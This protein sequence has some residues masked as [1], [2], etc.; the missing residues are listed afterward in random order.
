MYIT[1]HQPEHMPWLG[2]FHKLDQVETCVLLDS[3]P[4]SK[5]Y[6]QNRNK[7]RNQQGWTWITV[8]VHRTLGTL[9]KDVEI[10]GDDRWKKKWMQTIY[11]S[12]NKSAYAGD[13]LG[14]IEEIL[15]RE[16]SNIS[17][18]NINLIYLLCSYLGIST[19]FI[20]SSE[21]E[22]EGKGSDLILNICQVMKASEYLS[23]IS[24]RDY[25]KIDE[26]G[27]S[28]IS[29]FFQEF[30]HPIYQQLHE[31]FMPC[32]SV[33]DLLCNHGTQSLELLRGHGV[34]TIDHLYT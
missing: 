32:M 33:I 14:G 34:P 26:F 15:N 13:Y 12:Y 27:N 16:W 11:H 19:R 31:P 30:Y 29:V 18:L 9:I 23:G 1:I 2:F 8:P 6:F 5:N 17:D 7:V 3:V 28:G 25:L 21:L 4:F 10:A 22:I 20:L 24:G